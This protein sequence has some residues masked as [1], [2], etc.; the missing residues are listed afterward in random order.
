MPAYRDIAARIASEITTRELQPGTRIISVRD[1]AAREGV[2]VP[3][4]LAALRVLEA[5]GLIVARPRSGWYIGQQPPACLEAVAVPLR[6][7]RVTTGDVAR[8]LF[9]LRGQQLAPFGAGVPQETWLPGA[10]LSRT[11]HVTSRRLGA[12]AHLYSYPPGDDQLRLRVAARLS[13]RGVTVTAD[14]LI[15]TSGA[16]QA[17]ELALRATTRPGDTVGVE[18]PCYFGTLLLLERLELKALELPTHPASGLDVE[19]AASII[20]QAKPAAIVAT[21]VLQNPTAA[22]MPLG[23]R[24]KLVSLLAASRVPLIEDDT[25]G[26]LAGNRE[27]PF[28]AF[29]VDGSVLY[30]GSA[31][32]TLAPGWRV[33]WIA[34]GRHQNTMLDGR[35][36]Q[37]L[38]GGRLIEASLAAYL[39]GGAYDR[40]LVRLRERVRYSSQVAIGRIASS[41]P[42]G[43]RLGPG[44]GGYG[45]W[46]ELPP[47][48]DALSIMRRASSSGIAVAPGSAFSPSGGFA[49]FL[50]LNIANDF[51]PK[52][53][54]ALD[55]LGVICCSTARASN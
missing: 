36:S 49:N 48:R 14:D 8:E 5:N 32:K 7:N 39:A 24:R 6:A 37:S 29:D 22:S 13:G 18:S 4:A 3:T 35:A 46:V 45:L 40:H 20:A 33:G 31:S 9:S 53:L 27:P 47:D 17:V 2:S 54:T 1:L 52:L 21:A 38:A 26:E 15:V 28:K 25:Y 44:R 51:T 34:A 55:R 12:K 42:S 11:L 19:R 16:T 41:F 50:R 30:C 43:T 10:D 23:E